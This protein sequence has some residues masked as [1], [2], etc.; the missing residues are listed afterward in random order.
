MKICP[1]CHL[2]LPAEDVP[3]CP[4]C[5]HNLTKD[6]YDRSFTTGTIWSGVAILCVIAGFV[7]FITVYQKTL[8]DQGYSDGADEIKNTFLYV[9]SGKYHEGYEDGVNLAWYFDEGCKDKASRRPPKYPE[10]EKYM[11]GYEFC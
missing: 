4:H 10:E 7:F 11:E 1:R 3:Y 6:V 2:T 5:E 8:Y 9:L